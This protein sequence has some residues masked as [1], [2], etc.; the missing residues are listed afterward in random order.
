[1]GTGAAHIGR[2]SEYRTAEPIPTPEQ[3]RAEQSRAEH[4][5]IMKNGLDRNRL[6]SA[7][8][9]LIIEFWGIGGLGN[10]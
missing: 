10:K 4:R 1:M 6:E 9:I 3:S 2:D 7:T 8:A 5:T